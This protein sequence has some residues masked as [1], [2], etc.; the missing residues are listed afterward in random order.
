MDLPG[1]GR[2]RANATFF[3]S[4]ASD[5][6]ALAEYAMDLTPLVVDDTLDPAEFALG[7]VRRLEA[8]VGARLGRFD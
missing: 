7:F 3:N 1:A 5:T 2:G 6:A 8:D 4:H